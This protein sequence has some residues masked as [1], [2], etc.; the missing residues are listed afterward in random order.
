LAA[1]SAGRGGFVQGKSDRLRAARVG[2]DRFPVAAWHAIIAWIDSIC[3]GR[4]VIALDDNG[5]RPDTGG[6]DHHERK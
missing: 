1:I 5:L 6:T 3:A 4:T 2:R